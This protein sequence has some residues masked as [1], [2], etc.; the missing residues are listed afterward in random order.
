MITTADNQAIRNGIDPIVTAF[1]NLAGKTEKATLP[2]NLK[3]QENL[4]NKISAVSTPLPVGST[5]TANAAQYSGIRYSF[6]DNNM[7]IKWMSVDI[8]PEK[9]IL[10]YE[11]NTGEH[12]IILGMGEY[13]LQKFPEKYFGVQIGTKDTNYD[14]I[15]A[16][17]WQD[18]NTLSGVIYSID[19]YL[20]SIHITL[21]FLNDKLQ[22]SM[23]KTAEWFFDAYQGTAESKL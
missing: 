15:A 14:S 7:G 13:I 6:G 23:S 10:H 9:C 3:A 5:T 21:S 2:E 4:A 18:E 8:T 16:G 1:F 22:V 12:N 17:A 19:D 20:G 11:N